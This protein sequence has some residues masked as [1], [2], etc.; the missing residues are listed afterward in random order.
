M[1]IDNCN[2]TENAAEGQGGSIYTSNQ[3]F[4]IYSCNFTNSFVVTSDPS[5]STSP[6]QGGAIWVSNGGEQGSI[7]HSY[8]AH[9]MARSGWGG[10]IYGTG[11]SLLQIN[12]VAFNG[13]HAT[14]SYTNGALGGAIMVTDGVAITLNNTVF[15][16]N[17]ARP[18]YTTTPLT[19]SGAGGA[20]Y[21]QS[22]SVGISNCYF[23][24]NAAFTGQFD[25]GATGG[26]ILVENCNPMTISY[27]KFISNF[28]AG[29]FGSASY[30]SAGTGGALYIKFSVANV[31]NSGFQENWV[32][33]GG[34]ANSLGGAVAVFFDY[35]SV[36]D[37]TAGVMFN[38]THFANNSAFNEL[39]SI[40]QA[41]TAGAVGIVGV[42]SP[43][44]MMTNLT[45][46]G[47]VAVRPSNNKATSAGGAIA[48]SLSSNMT[49][50]DAVFNNN[51]AAFGIGN[52]V[53]SLTSTADDRNYLTFNRVGFHSDETTLR[54]DI[55]LI[56]NRTKSL[57][58]ILSD[59]E[60]S[61][62][63][64]YA[65]TSQQSAN[66]FT[67]QSQEMM[68]RKIMRG[69]YGNHGKRH[70]TASDSKRY[71]MER[72]WETLWR[73]NSHSN[74][75]HAVANGDDDD[76]NSPLSLVNFLPGLAFAAGSA[77]LQD[78]TF[79]GKYHIFVGSFLAISLAQSGDSTV[80]LAQLDS[81]LE[82][83]GNALGD[84][85][86]LTV[87][88]ATC[89]ID[90]YNQMDSIL[91]RELNV[92]NGTLAVSSDV[93][94]SRSSFLYNAILQ[95][96]PSRYGYSV[97]PSIN[98]IKDVLTG[99][100]LAE[101][102]SNNQRTI[103]SIIHRHDNAT[104]S[105]GTSQAV[106]NIDK[107]ILH[108]AGTMFIDSPYRG[109]DIIFNSSDPNVIN[110]IANCRIELYN[111]ASIIIDNKG[112][113]V[114]FTSVL[115][116]AQTRDS[117]AIINRGRIALLGTSFNIINGVTT[118][119]N[120]L[121]SVLT[122]FGTFIQNSTGILDLI[123][124]TTFQ[125]QPVVSL[126]DNSYFGGKINV[127]FSD[128]PNLVLY[129]DNPS[130]FD[131]ISYLNTTDTPYVPLADI[132]AP[133]GLG[134]GIN[135]VPTV[136]TAARTSY[137]QSLVLENMACS[138]VDSSYQS[139]TSQPPNSLYSCYICLQNSSCEQ[140][141]YSMCLEKGLCSAYGGVQY[142]SSCCSSSC[143][144]PYGSCEGN[145]DKTEFKCECSTWFYVG[146]NCDD[147]S[148]IAIVII[149]TGTF[150]VSTALLGFFIYRRSATQKQQVLEE[151]RD[152]IL[153]H[154][155]S[156][157]NE[158][159]LNMQQALI[160]NDVFVKFDEIKLESKIGEGSFGIVHKATFR[161]AQ[162][163]VKQMR[164]MFIELTDKDIEE[165]RREAYVMSRY[166]NII[167]FDFIY[168]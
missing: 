9:N 122:V 63:D 130:T 147:P 80:N 161:G 132:V 89:F 146:S 96:L 153:R 134:F 156:A 70:L 75:F 142:S 43:P 68:R 16:K 145:K 136:S 50:T 74:H 19:Y 78:T 81:R 95:G 106:M 159:I 6:S 61:F 117:P 30:A 97:V 27:T 166:H 111:N 115:V 94:V 108:V 38:S 158:Y 72:L 113:M 148:L 46:S 4:S 103:I 167:V 3:K 31:D 11:A 154:T 119:T 131:I 160:L 48:V 98:F 10:A 105:N 71:D 62:N 12:D 7:E 32:S 59:L 33:A 21:A 138:Q 99:Y 28:A 1:L 29:F 139:L 73:D 110:R 109:T 35:S 77:T 155:E 47:N 65:Q 82:I 143:N 56:A 79:Q 26:A 13:N 165:F 66:G 87:L 114:L 128:D 93:N 125:T 23:E 135:I 24:S 5:F 107:C 39:C 102:T 34:S 67:H 58:T 22:V 25:A 8:F 55:F 141:G 57:C 152:G 120:S 151:L 126:V 45:F 92:F 140:C 64:A 49:I 51:Y 127:S 76:S 2:F 137:Q 118:A 100:T 69:I 60:A 52:D 133:Y 129:S 36:E 83:L 91:L 53:A 149:F 163:A 150:V 162:V 40:S 42:A 84:G 86:T 37:S 157:N 14:S 104:V 85:V 168:T 15:L 90:L 17:F 101:A 112:S 41:G 20:L 18:N 164:S 44:V 88:G 121:D 123:L 144:P 116:M 124:N 54:H